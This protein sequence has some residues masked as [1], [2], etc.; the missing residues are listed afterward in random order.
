MVKLEMLTYAKWINILVRKIVKSTS[1][2]K[3]MRLAAM[4]NKNINHTF[5]SSF[6]IKIKDVK[7]LNYIAKKRLFMC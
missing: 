3:P 1:P 6:L 5:F 2:Y 7:D 4:L